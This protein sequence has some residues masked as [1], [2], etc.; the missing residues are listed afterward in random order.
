MMATEAGGW[1]LCWR[2]QARRWSDR[3]CC[4]RRKSGDS[5]PTQQ[6]GRLSSGRATRHRTIIE[7]TISN[8]LLAPVFVAL[9]NMRAKRSGCQSEQTRGDGEQIDV[10]NHRA[11]DR[12]GSLT[13]RAWLELLCRH[14]LARTLVRVFRT[15]KN[16]GG[17]PGGKYR[18]SSR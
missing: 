10:N 2:G 7:L 9:H 6:P 4:V 16:C 1:T 14:I 12:D 13:V 17:T 8:K 15:D 3:T 11:G 5:R 18:L